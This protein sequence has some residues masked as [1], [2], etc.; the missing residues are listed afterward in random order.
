MK[1]VFF[2][3]LAANLVVGAF[4]YIRETA[5]NPDAQLRQMQM[6]ADQINVIPAPQRPPA[7]PP[8]SAAAQTDCLDWG[9]FGPDQVARAQAV[10]DAL[11]FG[12]RARPK[13]VSVN[14]AFW[15]YMPPL[16]SQ[17]EMDRKIREL[18]QLG[19][20]EHS[21]VLEPGRWRYA[22]SLGAFRSQK[23]ARAYLAQLQQ[24]GVRSAA[25]GEREQRVT[26]T[27]FTISEPSAE[28]SARLSNL[29]AEFPGSELKA[30]A[31]PGTD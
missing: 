1:W 7:P 12:E 8:A 17:A 2:L 28:E 15:V 21:P 20:T 18:S 29:Q 9:G 24:K 23:D 25:I 19:V 26:Q 10:L 27:A 3:L 11:G 30:V 31:C 6:N 16:R 22:I 5:P 14:M 4:L 13:Q